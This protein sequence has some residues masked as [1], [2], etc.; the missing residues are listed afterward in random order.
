MISSLAVSNV[1]RAASSC[2][3]RVVF[4]DFSS[5][6]RHPHQFPLLCTL[7]GDPLTDLSLR[8]SDLFPHFPDFRLSRKVTFQSDGLLRNVGA[9]GL[10]R[11]FRPRVQKARCCK[12]KTAFQTISIL[13]GTRRPTRAVCRANFVNISPA[14]GGAHPIPP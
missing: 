13:Y 5:K 9:I 12:T 6:S 8:F 4:G 1:L 2:H 7:P 14:A 3:K 11:S 10:F